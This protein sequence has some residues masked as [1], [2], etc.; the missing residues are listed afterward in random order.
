M[1]FFPLIRFAV[2]FVHDFFRMIDGFT[3]FL[4]PT[5]IRLS[6]HKQMNKI[7]K[8]LFSNYQNF[9]LLIQSLLTVILLN[10]LIICD[11]IF[12][13][14]E[15]RVDLFSYSEKN[16]TI[17]CSSNSI[18]GKYTS[19]FP[20]R[21]SN[22]RFS[23]NSLVTS[24]SEGTSYTIIISHKIQFIEN[25]QRYKKHFLWVRYKYDLDQGFQF[26]Q[27]TKLIYFEKCSSILHLSVLIWDKQ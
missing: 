15:E 11:K 24:S 7:Q 12:L 1:P 4:F 16:S 5:N 19:T 8:Y 26:Q 2:G 13:A 6:L 20:G 27:F 3:Q 10:I 17:F 9:H 25:G 23:G 22:A 21:G 18:N 14:F